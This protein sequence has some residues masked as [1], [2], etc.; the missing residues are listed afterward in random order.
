MYNPDK[1]VLILC[2]KN[3]ESY[4][5]KSS[6]A[7]ISSKA[8]QSISDLKS[9]NFESTSKL[10]TIESEAFRDDALLSAFELPSSVKTIGS[11]AFFG[12]KSLQSISFGNSISTIDS[13]SFQDCESLR[14]VIF[15][16]CFSTTIGESAFSGCTKLNFLSLSNNVTRIEKNCFSG[17]TSLTEV[18]FP[19]SLEFIGVYAFSNSGL[20]TITVPDGTHMI[21]FCPS[22]FRNCQML[23]TLN[24][25]STILEFEENCLESTSITS[26]TVP[27][28]TTSI[29]DYAFKNCS[30]MTKFTIPEGCSLSSLGSLIFDGCDSLSV[31]ECISNNYFEVDNGA[32]YKKGRETLY[33]FPPASPIKFFNLP[34]N[35]RKISA[36]AFINC[37]NIV[38]ISIPDQSVET[39]GSYAFLNCVS[40]SYI[41]IPLC[42]KNVE[43]HAFLGCD[44]LRCGIK[45]ENK[46]KTFIRSLVDTSDLLSSSLKDCAF[47][48]CNQIFYQNGFSHFSYIYVFILM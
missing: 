20:V 11:S 35:L 24:I 32:L 46:N 27:L 5:I 48:S 4:I 42:V 15:V 21:S 2:L 30:S 7:K 36:N 3:S 25:P 23:Q 40:L 26:F 41:N 38:S 13:L 31:I 39:I 10:V 19:T 33:F 29:A 6:V 16:S 44:N 22:S 43:P 17:C 34:Q 14:R 12:C 47:I 9:I 37:K 45:I 28:S 18:V 1:S 8:F